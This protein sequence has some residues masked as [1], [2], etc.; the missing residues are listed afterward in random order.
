MPA[1]AYLYESI[2]HPEAFLVDG[3]PNSMVPNFGSRNGALELERGSDEA[4]RRELE[5]IGH[6]VRLEAMTSGSHIIVRRP[7]G[8]L[9]GGA[10]PRREGLALGD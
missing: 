10:D 5:T 2:I 1:D 4:L 3:Y 8:L 7:D 6:V 9:E